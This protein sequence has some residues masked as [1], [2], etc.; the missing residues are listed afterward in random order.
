MN[1]Y[2]TF[3]AG[4]ALL[5]TTALAS[6]TVSAASIQLSGGNAGNTISTFTGYKIGNT[7]FTGAASSSVNTSSASFDIRAGTTYTTQSTR[8]VLLISGGEF[9]TSTTPTA[10]LAQVEGTSSLTNISAV[11]TANVTVFTDRIIIGTLSQTWSV[12]HIQSPTVKNLQS[13]GTPGNIV[14]VSGR[15]ENPNVSATYENIDTSTY[16][17]SVVS[18]SIV[19]ATSTNSNGLPSSLGT[20]ASVSS[21]PPFI[22][23][24]TTGGSAIL[25]A[26]VGSVSLT[27][28]GALGTSLSASLSGSTLISTAELKITH[29][30]LSDPAFNSISIR[31]G[32]TTVNYKTATQIAAGVA[33]FSLTGTTIGDGT[34]SVI[35]DIGVTGSTVIAG[36]SGTGAATLTPTASNTGINALAAVTGNLATIGTGGLSTA[37]NTF[38]NSANTVPSFLRL[39]NQSTTA[40]TY[41]ITIRNGDAASGALLGTYTG[42][43][44]QP[45]GTIQLSA[46]QIEAGAGLTAPTALGNYQLAIVAKFNGYVQ[47]LTFSSSTGV[48]SNLS[49]FR[50]GVSGGQLAP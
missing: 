26:V 15:I 31:T 39:T 46:A 22:N 11:A 1:K 33:T 21:S 14:T 32:T 9:D 44:V 12:M 40:G 37:V 19:F 24:G 49:A 7:L 20:A 28:F 27:L 43:T 48:L 8:A 35:I 13:L 50:Q 47:H 34:N 45:Q 38:Q 29:G 41:T 16:L 18:A 3:L 36:G 30:A 42:A 23:F 2:S 4:S 25:T 6:G 17:T 10:T 5:A